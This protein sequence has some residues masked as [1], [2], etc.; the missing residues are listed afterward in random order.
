MVKMVAV[1]SPAKT[2]DYETESPVDKTTDYRMADEAQ[3]L[4]SVLRQYSVDD[5]KQLMKLSDAL[6][7]LNVDR[8]KSWQPE[9]TGANSKQALFAFKGD[10]YTGLSAYTLTKPQINAAQRQL[11]ILSGLY[12]LLRPLDAIQPYRLEMGKPLQTSRGKNL[13][14][15]WGDSV[16][17]LLNEDIQ[18]LGADYL[19]NL[20]SQEYFRAV[21]SSAVCVPIITP[22]F[23]DEKN[24]EFKIISFF[25]KK[26]RGL[27]IRYI[28]DQQPTSLKSL[29]A[30]NY[31]GYKFCEDESDQ[32]NWV[33][34]RNQQP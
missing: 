7:E 1:I 24:G 28:L 15:F 5:V 2:L 19:I 26:A 27:M 6:A 20:A 10:V 18:E 14:E 12:G 29:K 17:D 23:K 9:M 13:Y 34:K 30:F 31:D 8:F 25:A 16:T 21:K 32:L 22:I 4:V 11:R 3:S 33:F